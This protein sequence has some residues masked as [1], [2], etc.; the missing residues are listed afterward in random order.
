M[1]P[2]P[3]RTLGDDYPTMWSGMSASI[4]PVRNTHRPQL[5][6]QRLLLPLRWSSVASDP[7]PP[8]TTDCSPASIRL[9]RG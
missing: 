9:F 1:P 5:A 8:L 2:S 3:K 6:D 4:L 7:L